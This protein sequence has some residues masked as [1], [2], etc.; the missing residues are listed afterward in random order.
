MY[1]FCARAT[2]GISCVA[3]VFINSATGTRTRVARVRAEYPNQL[4]YGGSEGIVH[5]FVSVFF[6]LYVLTTQFEGFVARWRGAT[7]PGFGE[8]RA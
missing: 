8:A 5:V 2:H 7:A 1:K 6:T 3:R 4:G